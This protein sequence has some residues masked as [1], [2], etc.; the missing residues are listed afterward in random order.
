MANATRFTVY[1]KYN[2]TDKAIRR[3]KKMTLPG[4]VLKL[5]VKVI[6]SRKNFFKFSGTAY[7]EDEIIATSNFSAMIQG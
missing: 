6:S 1:V 5:K 2:E 4:N 3:F 7:S